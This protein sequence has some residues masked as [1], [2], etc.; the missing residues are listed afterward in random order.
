[1]TGDSY[2]YDG[3]RFDFEAPAYEVWMADAPALGTEAPDF[4]LVDLDGRR[5]RLADL[6][7]RPVVIEFGSYTC[8]I[9]CAQVPSMRALALGHPEASFLAIYAREA[10]PGEITGPHT[11][12]ET[13]VEAARRLARDEDLGRTLLVDDLDGRVHRAYGGVWDPAFV[14]DG[15]GRVVLRRAWNDPVQ[16]E[17][18]LDALRRNEVPA[19]IES[20]EMVPVADAG[21]M[22]HGLLRGGEK[23]VL[24]FYRSMPAPVKGLLEN[25]HSEDVRRIVATAT[26]SAKD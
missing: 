19:L 2:N 5:H 7:G 8:P 6:R 21:G 18:T 3:Y 16:V 14:L 22:G 17:Q 10:H 11:T 24:D 15:S 23:A 1:M 9:F 26:A 4:E 13:K 20:I 12:M 25:S